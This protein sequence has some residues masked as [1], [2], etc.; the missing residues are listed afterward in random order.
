MSLARKVQATFGAAVILVLALAL[1]IPYIWMGKLTTKDLLD[2]GR[3]RSKVLLDRH[4]QLEGASQTLRA[5]D[6]TGQVRDPNDAEIRWLRFAQEDENILSELSKDA[7]N[8]IEALRDDL[9]RDDDVYLAKTEGRLESNYV[10]IF[11]ATD[12]CTNCHNPQGTASPFD[13]NK[14][15]GAVLIRSRDLASGMSNTI[16]MNRIWVVVAGLIGGTGA[17]VTFY[18][19]TQRLILRPIRQLR[20]LANN[21]AEGN[22]EIRSAIATRDE[23]EKLA[24]AFN[25]MLD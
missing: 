14:P 5:L 20:A 22:L 17:I 16:L 6:S 19:I 10:R 13:L 23:Y 7:K 24:K 2:A 21:V 4:F 18:M 9:D 8:V 12:H 15:I 25:H 11:R 1:S 3:S